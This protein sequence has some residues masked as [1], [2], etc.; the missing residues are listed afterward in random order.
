MNGVYF[1]L[2]NPVERLDEWFTSAYMGGPE[3]DWFAISHA[4]PKGGDPARWDYLSG[5]L[6]DKDMAQ[7]ANYEELLEYLNVDML[8]DY[9]IVHWY[10]GVRDWPGNNWWGGNRN[11][12]PEPFMYFS[13]DGEWSF[14]V[15]QGSPMQP[16]VH[17]DFLAGVGKGGGPSTARIFNSAKDSPEFRVAFADRVYNALYNDGALTDD[18]AR[19]RWQFLNDHLRTPVVAE[20]ARWGDAVIGGPTRTRDVDW[21]NEVDFQDAY[22]DGAAATLVSALRTEGYYPLVDPPL[23]FDMG[24]PLEV[25]SMELDAGESVVVDIERDGE[26]GVVYYTLDGSDPRAVG[27]EPQGMNAGE[28]AQ[29]EVV[30]PGVLKS[31]TLDGNDWSAVHVFELVEPSAGDG[32]GDGDGDEVGDTG[33]DT[34]GGGDGDGDSD[35][36][37]DG[38][39]DGESGTGG[40]GDGEGSGCSCRTAGTDVPWSGTLALLAVVGLRR[41]TPWRA[42]AG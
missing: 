42:W 27:G 14:G 32:D 19:E 31:R 25:T 10:A 13:W 12:P 37:G 7:L 39:G 18:N 2:Y 29:A 22:M 41:R 3:T 34:G 6:K 30:S 35:S 11:V 4:G 38:D 24:A 40:A 9:L 17:P 28:S 16:Q 23:Y 36:G 33:N 8:A 21:Q 1:G 26:V 15:G 5:A 20:S